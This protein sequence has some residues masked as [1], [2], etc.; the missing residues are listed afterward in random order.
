MVQCGRLIFPMA[1]DHSSTWSLN[2]LPYAHSQSALI[3]NCSVLS[4]GQTDTSN[5]SR[6]TALREGKT[7]SLQDLRRNFCKAGKVTASVCKGF[8][9]LC[10]H[11][12]LNHTQFWTE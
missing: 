1:L 12:K 9:Q 4:L 3:K 11:G 10:A 7:F 8:Q 5:E 6:V 2:Y